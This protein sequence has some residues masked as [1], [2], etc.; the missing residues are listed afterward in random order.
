VVALG[1]KPGITV[2]V[3]AGGYAAWQSAQALTTVGR[4]LKPEGFNYITYPELLAAQPGD[5]VLVDLRKL[6]KEVLKNSTSLT[7]LKQEFPG[8][9]VNSSALAQSAGE[10][11]SAPLLVLIDSADGSSEAAA[12]LLKAKG[13]RRYAILLGGEL[14]IVRKGKP[15]SE[16]TGSSYH[17]STLSN[18]NHL[19]QPVN[20][21]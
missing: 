6:T 21:P 9:R 8:R 7:D 17:G 1:Q 3:L 2:E 14:T 13:V 15:G 11:G 12:R 20:G 5:V 19:L 4:G 16:R 18:Q 10:P